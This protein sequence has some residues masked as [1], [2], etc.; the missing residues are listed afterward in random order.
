MNLS[1]Q[2]PSCW[3]KE[4]KQIGR[5]RLGGSRPS[6]LFDQGRGTYV[7]PVWVTVALL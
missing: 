1:L 4:T 2:G 6:T 7:R 3:L 5:A